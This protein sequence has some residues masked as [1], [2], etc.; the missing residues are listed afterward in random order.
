[1]A[2]GRLHAAMSTYLCI[3]QDMRFERVVCAELFLGLRSKKEDHSV[4]QKPMIAESSFCTSLS[5]KALSLRGAHLPTHLPRQVL[6]H[7]FA[8]FVLVQPRVQPLRVVPVQLLFDCVDHVPEEK[9][10][11]R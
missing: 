6:L 2:S 7:V 11:G 3:F 4:N 9:R 5:V 10:E 1:M 8:S